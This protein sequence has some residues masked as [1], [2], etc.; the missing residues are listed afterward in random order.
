[1]LLSAYR[2]FCDQYAAACRSTRTIIAS[3]ARVLNTSKLLDV[4]AAPGSRI[5]NATLVQR[6]TIL[7]TPDEPTTIQDGAWVSDSILQHG[8]HIASHGLVEKSVLCE[9]S[10]VE[11]QGKVSQS[12]LGP[13]T[14]IAEGEVTSSLVG[15]F[16]G[17]HHQSLLIAAMW[18]EGRG[19]IGSGANVGSN[20]TSKAPDQEIWP[21]EG[22]F[23]GLGVNIKYPTDFTRAPYTIIATAVNALPQR[24]EFPFSLINSPTRAHEGVLPGYNEITPAWVLSDDI[25]LVMRNEA[26][27][28]ARNKARRTK[29]E[30][31]VF[32]PAIIDLMR[33]A[34][35]RLQQVPEV[36]YLYTDKDIAGLGKNFL[37]EKPRLAAIETYT[38][39]IRYYAL[40]GFLREAEKTLATEP[41]CGNR[42]L[43]AR[44]ADSFRWQ[45]ERDVLSQEFPGLDAPE[46]FYQLSQHQE[47][48]AR[49]VQASKERDDSRGMRIIS[50]Y[51]D[52]H[53]PASQ[54]PFV[55]SVWEQTHE[56]N[57]KLQK[58]IA[59]S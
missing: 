54:D 19:N 47:K 49:D 35:V 53:A 12:I 43:L 50:D 9:Y 6:T 7:A 22:A 42:E 16:V 13:N 34:R 41:R 57:E 37:L 2:T 30:T 31:E 4:Y 29:L 3:G 26:K 17:F 58:L 18:P 51:R 5:D 44:Q 48:V 8:A 20:H 33:D 23:F 21:G 32:R 15:P 28:R 55:Q 40:R 39:Y 10:S 27:F 11:R 46:L 36:K 45:H 56:L 38:F 52:A 59:A 24:V 1:M 14:S 25:Y